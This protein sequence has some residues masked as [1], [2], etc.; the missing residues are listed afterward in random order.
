MHVP[1]TPEDP[2]AFPDFDPINSVEVVHEG[3]MCYAYRLAALKL[4]D[5]IPPLPPDRL[6]RFLPSSQAHIP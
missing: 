4:T 6:T 3:K 2:A 1:G 5:L